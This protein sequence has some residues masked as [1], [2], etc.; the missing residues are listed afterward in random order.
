MDNLDEFAKIFI[1][2]V[3]DNSI[4]EMEMRIDS[5]MRGK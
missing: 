2:E 4:E 5:R 1:K 3:R